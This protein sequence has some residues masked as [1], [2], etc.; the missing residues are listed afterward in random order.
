[1]ANDAG[2]DI[3]TLEHRLTLLHENAWSLHVTELRYFNGNDWCTEDAD[4]NLVPNTED[5]LDEHCLIVGIG[6]GNDSALQSYD[7][8]FRGVANGAQVAKSFDVHR[9]N[10]RGYPYLANFDFADVKSNMHKAKLRLENYRVDSK[11]HSIIE[12]YPL[13]VSFNFLKLN[14]A[15]YDVYAMDPETYPNEIP[16]E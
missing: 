12:T 11:S 7:V 8:W 3:E 14:W 13:D 15:N 1:M 9:S 2:F 4:G 16:P 6:Y 5:L 10:Y